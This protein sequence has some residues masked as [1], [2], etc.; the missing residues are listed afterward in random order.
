CQDFNQGVRHF[1]AAL[2]LSALDARLHQNLAL[3]YEWLDNLA[4]ADPHWN[5]YFELIDRRLPCP[6]GRTDYVNDLAFEGLSRLATRYADKERWPTAIVYL[7]RARQLRPDNADLL[8][9]LFQLYIHAQRQ[10]EARQVLIELRKLRPADP[11]M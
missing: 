7:E 3:A 6:P 1:T 8:E 10:A 9:R 4:E 5:R 11:Q 2:K